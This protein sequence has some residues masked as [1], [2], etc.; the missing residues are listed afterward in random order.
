MTELVNTEDLGLCGRG[1]GGALLESGA[2]AFGGD[3]PVNVSG[4]PPVVR[5]PGRRDRR[6][7]DRGDGDHVTGRAGE[8][9]VEGARLGAAHTLGGPGMVSTVCVVGAAD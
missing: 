9:Q 6:A 7:D 1:E 3:I 2:T 8:R 4:G 5:A